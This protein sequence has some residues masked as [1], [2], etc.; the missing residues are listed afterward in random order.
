MFSPEQAKGLAMFFVDGLQREYVT[1]QKVLA[2]VP[3]DKMDFKLGD[4]GKTAAELMWHLVS[5]D[6]WFAES[7]VA[8]SFSGG[9][10]GGAAPATGAEM[11]AR[12]E[13]I[14]GLLEK[15]AALSPEH[16]ATP[17]SFY[18]VFNLPCALYL[19]FMNSHSIHHR[20]QLSTYL[21]AMNAHVPS[22]YGGSAD[23]PFQPGPT[24]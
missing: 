24:A 15:A 18:G 16:L 2:A 17:V 22:I 3:A 23:E 11:I 21:R 7:I 14:P 13:A 1:T 9:E 20:G 5:S 6:I 19:N 10:E 4:K 12:Y 8:G